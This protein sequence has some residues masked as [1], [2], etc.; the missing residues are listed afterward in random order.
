MKKSYKFGL[1]V[2]STFL[3]SVGIS[4]CGGGGSSSSSNTATTTSGN[5]RDANVIGLEYKS[6]AISGITD[7]NGSYTCEDGQNVTFSLGNV[8]LGTVPCGQLITPVELVTNGSADNQTV[9]NI[10]KFLTMVDND[11]NPSNGMTISQ[12]VRTLAKNWSNVDFT[13]TSFNTDTNVTTIVNDINNND[14]N[15]TVAHSLP[16]DTNAKNHLKSTLICAYSGAFSGSFQGDDNGGIGVL[17]SPKTGYMYTVG[18]SQGL[19]QYFEGTGTQG[20]GFDNNRSIQGT[21]S[22]GASFTGKITTVNSVS[23]NWSDGT[24]TGNFSAKRVGGAVNVQYRVVGGYSG[25]AKGLFS[26]DIDSNNKIT[27]IAYNPSL[28]QSYSISGDLNGSL[29]T[30][31]SSDGATVTATFDKTTGAISNAQWSNTNTATSGTFIG[32][33]CKLN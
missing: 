32:S 17:I 19:K 29:M 11:G 27:G 23:G 30:A 15:Y 5:F 18:Y 8:T 10:V 24:S 2:I 25:D 6:G 21:V 33:G 4:G 22:T 12:D 9:V 1:S 3:L 20:F 14:N 26:F 13:S 28:D 16:T 7:T 31:T